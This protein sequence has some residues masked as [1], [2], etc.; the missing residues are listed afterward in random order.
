[1]K[2][3]YIPSIK[4]RHRIKKLTH[5]LYSL[6]NFASIAIAIILK[7]GKTVW[8]SSKPRISL[9]TFKSGLYR[10]DL[11]LNYTFI[12]D[13]ETMFPNDFINLDYLQQL[14]NDILTKYGLYRCYCFTRRCD[15]CH[16]LVSVNTNVEIKDNMS[17]YKST[18]DQIES[19]SLEFIDNMLDVYLEC[20]PELK[21][22]YF[23]TDKNYRHE[24]L[25]TKTTLLNINKLSSSELSVLYWSAKGKSSE[26]ISTILFLSK[27]T[28]DTYRRRLI[29]KLNVAN[30][31]EAVYSAISLGLII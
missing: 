29:K 16:I 17:Y 7:S 22:T 12:K 13:K 30:I 15:D 8:L 28:V 3:C 26:E 2:E 24:V 21:S 11:L 10:G 25:K 14:V 1:M 9:N 27:N 4:Y 6:E 20:L 31:T 18:I 5:P 19:F 23:M